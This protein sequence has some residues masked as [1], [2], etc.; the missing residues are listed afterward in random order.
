MKKFISLML[1]TIMFSLT[2]MGH[3]E[4][5]AIQYSWEEEFYGDFND[6][7]VSIFV[8]KTYK[9][10]YKIYDYYDD[11]SALSNV[12]SVTYSSSNPSVAVVDSSGKVTGKK[13]G[14]AT[15]KAIFKIKYYDSWYDEYALD[16]LQMSYTVYVSNP[17]LSYST[18]YLYKKDTHVLK[19]YGVNG[20]KKWKSSNKKV[21]TVSASGKIK[22]KKK[23]K[24]T[25]TCY[26]NG[27]TMKC[28]VEVSNP[29]LNYKSKTVTVGIKDRLYIWGH[30]GKGK[31]KVKN[32]KI[33]SISKNGVIKGKKVGK[34][35]VY[36]K[37]DGVKLKCK[38]TIA[39]NQAHFNPSYTSLE[40]IPYSTVKFQPLKIYFSGK[41]MKVKGYIYNK[42]PK[43]IHKIPYI[44]CSLYVG[45][46]YI[47]SK[48]LYN[49]KIYVK[50]FSRKMITL[51]LANN[52]YYRTH[53]D[54]RTSGLTLNHY[55]SVE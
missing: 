6:D 16:T 43:A 21:A 24:A 32:S 53:L 36:C 44:K 28:K 20:K 25:I 41:K 3:T 45:G 15:I 8:N 52:N 1:L 4:V 13:A 30:S 14:S 46:S 48:E 26:V 31:W 22:A 7:Y 29:Q 12:Q 10:T 50:D 18:L 17:Y 40:Q 23:G 47:L 33:L 51:T 37:T 11:E 34:T 9:N 42:K 27:Q 39:K 5:Q 19:V 2:V 35:V 49:T 38:V 55:I 54:F